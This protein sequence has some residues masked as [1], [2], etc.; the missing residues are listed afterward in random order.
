MANLG[1]G[2][3]RRM[4]ARDPD[5]P[6]RAG[7][8]LELFFDL[9]FVVAV[10]FSSSQ[11]HHMESAGNLG[12]GVL[13]YLMVFFSIWW[14]W[15]NFTWFATSFDTD[16]WL[17][18]VT[19]LVQMA[20]VLVLAAGV[21]SAM[22]RQDFGLVTIGYVIM[23]L[24]MVAQWIR[25]A[26]SEPELR[27]TALRYAGAIAVV[28]TGWL[29]LLAL[30][31]TARFIGFFILVAAEISVPV[32]AEKHKTTPWHP[33]HIAER[34]S[35]F[36]IILLGESVLASANAVVGAFSAGHHVPD[37]VLISAA[38]LVIAA[39]IWWVYFAR[40]QHH[41]FT[42]LRTSVTF[43]YFHYFIFAA[44]GAF[45]VGVGVAIDEI[46]GETTLGSF[47]V[48]ALL[49]IP[50]A[51]YLLGVWW[52]LLRTL[53]SGAANGLWL[54]GVAVVL[55]GLFF[56]APASVLVAAAGMVLCVV[57]TELHGRGTR[58]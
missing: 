26:C 42:S 22:E 51:L 32:F 10:S 28:Q 57:S 40:E 44:V 52:L 38:G 13:N 1:R 30:P 5:E 54:A 15:M 12:G 35:A 48:S 47:E 33:A 21:D 7:S 14:A 53:L 9:V 41:H 25:A 17:Y 8:S 16:D 43:G 11:L 45:S 27:S 58:V 4:T 31:D 39:G 37:L 6:N 50:L 55:C 29:V 34:Y 49:S 23:R 2:A 20:G 56:P 46:S 36:T 24:A 3:L 19:T 18:R